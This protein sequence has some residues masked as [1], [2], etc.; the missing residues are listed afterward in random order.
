MYVFLQFFK[1][2][3]FSAP[4]LRNFLFFLTHVSVAHTNA[5]TAVTSRNLNFGLPSVPS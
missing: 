2:L 4:A 5:D 1:N 3:I